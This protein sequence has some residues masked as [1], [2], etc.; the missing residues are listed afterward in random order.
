MVRRYLDI[1]FYQACLLCNMNGIARIAIG[2]DN[3][4]VVVNERTRI[5]V[6]NPEMMTPI[7][8]KELLVIIKK[9]TKFLVRI[10]V[11]AAISTR[12][13]STARNSEN[14]KNTEWWFNLCSKMD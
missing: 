6:Q 10:N 4:V 12:L 13:T 5:R 3:I 2:I 1:P 9:N 8:L 7:S 14:P 11:S